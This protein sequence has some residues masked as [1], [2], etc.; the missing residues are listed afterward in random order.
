MAGG[1][2]ALLD[3]IATMAKLAA[4]SLDDV[5]AGAAK[6][7]AKAVGVVIDDT[8]VTPQYVRGL[9]PARELP[10][11]W[12]IAR[13]SLLNK[14]AIILPAAL[15]LSYFAP[16]SLPILLL[17]G[18]T[19][20]C[21]EGAEKVLVKMHVLAHHDAGPAGEGEESAE[22]L[23]KRMVA[24]AI[25]TDLILS[26]EIMLISLASLQQ[27]TNTMRVA[28]LVAVALFMT[29]FVYGLVAL[30]VKM[31]DFGAAL[32]TRGGSGAKMGETIVRVMPK[33]FDFIGIV[34]TVAM[35]WV[36]GHI[37][38]VSLADL[39]VEFL[40]H[41]VE[42]MVHAVEAAGPVATWL[43][44]TALS[45]VFGFLWG[46]LAAFVVVGVQKVL[47][48]RAERPESGGP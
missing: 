47:K 37:V 22:A 23:E 45:G 2:I 44:D 35:L 15:L 10:I 1:L 28:I 4:S 31:D 5:A 11:I 29:L 19:Y 38:I 18:G 40:H 46:S 12:R 25:R 13:G 39:H 27:E 36:G 17:V 16:W 6:A 7:S 20:L 33:V 9:S 34:G 32:V 48:L 3:D 21:Y 41:W 30:L 8:A 24:S 43:V 42:A 14:L 26:A